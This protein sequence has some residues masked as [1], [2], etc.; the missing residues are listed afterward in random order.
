MPTKWVGWIVSGFLFALLSV[1]FAQLLTSEVDNNVALEVAGRNTMYASINKGATRVE[2]EIS[3]NPE[4]AKEAFVRFYA[5]NTN[6]YDVEKTLYIHKINSKPP[7]IAV[8]SYSQTEGFF[9]RYTNLRKN[10]TEDATVLTQDL[11]LFI[12]EDI[13]KWK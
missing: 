6:F 1:T 4:V 11:K 7:L 8:E 9:K 3:I 5:E 2:R 12:W 10:Q 13:K